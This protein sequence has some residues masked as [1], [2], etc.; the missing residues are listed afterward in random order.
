MVCLGLEPGGQDWV[1]RRIHWAM[2]A[3]LSGAWLKPDTVIHL[4]YDGISFQL[5]MTQIMCASQSQG[6]DQWPI[7]NF[8]RL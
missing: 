3:P 6:S 2:A 1:H 5:E 7:L 8:L 4:S